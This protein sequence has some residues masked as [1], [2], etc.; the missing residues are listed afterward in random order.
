M[1]LGRGE[2]TKFLKLNP[3]YR[4][5]RKVEPRRKKTAIPSKTLQPRPTTR[6]AQAKSPKSLKM[7]PKTNLCLEEGDLPLWKT[8]TPAT[9]VVPEST[10][11]M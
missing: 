2:S 7:N 10:S 8:T 11:D 6:L 9:E 1:R 3:R 5:S 4:K